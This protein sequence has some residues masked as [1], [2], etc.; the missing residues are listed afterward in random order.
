MICYK[1]ECKRLVSAKAAVLLMDTYT[2]NGTPVFVTRKVTGMTGNSCGSN[3]EWCV[4]LDK[5]L[6]DGC[7]CVSPRFILGI[8]TG[9]MLDISPLVEFLH[10]KHSYLLIQERLMLS[11]DARVR[12]KDARP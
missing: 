8:N 12:L 1:E 11:G 10:K 4:N 3:S 9:G 2:E 5:A 6:S 7:S